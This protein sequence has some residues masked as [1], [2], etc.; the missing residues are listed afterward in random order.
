METMKVKDLMVPINKYVCI[1]ENASLG[2]A[3][4]ALIQARRSCDSNSYE[5][6]A[7]LVC[8]K[9]GDVLGRLSLLDVL[10]SLEPR[11]AELGDLKKYAGY[12]FTA[13]YLQAMM[14][15]YGI[16]QTPL[17]E[18]CRKSEDVKVSDIVAAPLKGEII[19][20]DEPL[21]RA[22]H[23]L[24]V[25]HFQSLLVRSGEQFIGLLRLTDVFEEVARRV[26]TC[27]TG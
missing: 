22:L 27:R 13:E 4:R 8:T 18:L 21:D 9:T 16:W 6:R 25:G 3:I 15:D 17:N 23:Q 2:D 14:K 26:E 19:D 20:E 12:V 10:R 7:V 1:A 5:Y 24:V 11:Y